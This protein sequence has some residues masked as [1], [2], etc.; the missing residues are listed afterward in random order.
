MKEGAL[1]ADRYRLVREIGSG[2]MG[3]VWLA[4]H[5]S[6][7]TSF[8]IKLIHS[9]LTSQ[10]EV[11]ARFS[12]EAQIAARLKSSHVVQVFDHGITPD[13][14]PFIAMEW[15][16]GAS[17]RERL[18]ARGRLKA[19]ETA[20]VVKHVCRALTRAHEAGLIHRDLKP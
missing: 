1:I 6:L 15:L 3:A 12:R 9:N 17:L 13:G 14:Q 11:R 18:D 4:E 20:R 2:G 10:A 8:A 7:K 16:E 19:D 5:T